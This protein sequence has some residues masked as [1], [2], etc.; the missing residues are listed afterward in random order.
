MLFEK[1]ELMASNTLATNLLVTQII[2]SLASFPH[3]LL[4]SVLTLPDVTFQPS[5]RGL[6]QAIASL[7]SKLD[8][9]MPTLAGSDEALGLAKRYLAERLAE[10]GSLKKRRDSN[11]SMA[12]AISQLG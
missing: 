12:S 2:S 6:P 7:R 1:V 10:P 3:P 11:I 5:V 8:N 9:I 4:R